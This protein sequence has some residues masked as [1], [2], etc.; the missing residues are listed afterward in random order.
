MSKP[1]P[2]L[3]H[4]H[5]FEV[6][7]RHLSFKKSAHEMNVTPAAI[8]QRGRSLESILKC[9][10]FVRHTRQVDLTPEGRLLFEDISQPL[11]GLK[12]SISRHWGRQNSPVLH[13][14][15]TNSFT[16]LNLLPVLPGFT[17]QFPDADVRIVSTN[18]KL[19][20]DK[21]EADVCIR[22]GPG[23]V[24]GIRSRCVYP[25]W[26]RPRA[27]KRNLFFWGPDLHSCLFT[28]P[29]SE[30]FRTGINGTY[31]RPSSNRR[32]VGGR[33]RICAILEEVSH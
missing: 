31:S 5:A 9:A 25:T 29:V 18:K 24:R 27:R 16:E 11:T 20:L 32:R 33:N 7:A 26:T 21:Y 14:S 23:P 15:T 28:G 1:L 13:I 2:P 10:L 22:L 12:N 30:I 4:L 3:D 19:D 17:D 6:A 8:G